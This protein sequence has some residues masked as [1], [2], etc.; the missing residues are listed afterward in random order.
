M[1]LAGKYDETPKH[2]Q[3]EEAITLPIAI[4]GC[5]SMYG[6]INNIAILTPV[7]WQAFTVLA[8]GHMVF[9]FWLP[10]QAWLKSEV[11]P[12]AYITINVIALSLGI[13]FYLILVVYAFNSFTAIAA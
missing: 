12:G 4:F 8:T 9:C 10:K 3:I 1:K 11:S 6:Y 7:F 5:L 2:V 13:P